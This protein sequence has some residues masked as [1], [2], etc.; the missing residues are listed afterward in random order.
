W[1]RKISLRWLRRSGSRA[2]KRPAIGGERLGGPLPAVQ[3]S[4]RSHS[5]PRIQ[6]LTVFL[7]LCAL[8]KRS[9]RNV[10]AFWPHLRSAGSGTALFQHLW[11]EAGTRQS[12]HRSGSH[13]RLA[14][15]RREIT[16]NLR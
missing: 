9:G 4:A 6:T 14:L 2:S 1:R 8:E 16:T 3:R 15:A 5:D 12:L 13:L 7:L 11:P 10:L